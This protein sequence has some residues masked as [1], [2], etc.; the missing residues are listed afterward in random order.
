MVRCKSRPGK[1]VRVETSKG[2]GVPGGER[3]Q[4]KAAGAQWS[5]E[6][7]KK[8]QGKCQEELEKRQEAKRTGREGKEGYEKGR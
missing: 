4:G 7:E 6:R 2:P 8:D 3:Q 5:G 1:A